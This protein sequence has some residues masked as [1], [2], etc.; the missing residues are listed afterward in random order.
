MFTKDKKRIYIHFQSL[1]QVYRIIDDYLGL[2]SKMKKRDHIILF[3]LFDG[4]L[5][6]F[7]GS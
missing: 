2:K 3:I 1:L 7:L 5:N 6:R 4:L